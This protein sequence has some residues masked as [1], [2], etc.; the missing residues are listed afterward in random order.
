MLRMT[1]WWLDDWML[2]LNPGSPGIS[3]LLDLAPG[4]GSLV[5]PPGKSGCQNSAYP[6]DSNFPDPASE[7]GSLVFPPLKTM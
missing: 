5:F 7:L 1:F 3:I 4:K 6:Q 2:T